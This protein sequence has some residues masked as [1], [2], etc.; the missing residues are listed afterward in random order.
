VEAAARAVDEKILRDAFA[1][2]VTPSGSEAL[3]VERE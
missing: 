2:A 1:V 3:P